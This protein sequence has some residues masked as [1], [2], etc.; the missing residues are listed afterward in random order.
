MVWLAVEAAIALGV[1]LFVMWWTMF[2]GRPPEGLDE[3]E[4]PEVPPA[5][6]DPG[7]KPGA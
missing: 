7:A 1:L 4:A 5:P 3:P 2:S 6:R